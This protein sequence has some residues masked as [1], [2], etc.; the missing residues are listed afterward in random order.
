MAQR[1]VP[2][3]PKKKYY[4]FTRTERGWERR[5]VDPEP[6]TA[7][8]VPTYIERMQRDSNLARLR[9]LGVYV[10]RAEELTTFANSNTNM[11]SSL[12]YIERERHI[13]NYYPPWAVRGEDYPDNYHGFIWPTFVTIGIRGGSPGMKCRLL[14][15]LHSGSPESITRTTSFTGSSL[16]DVPATATIQIFTADWPK[17]GNVAMEKPWPDV[18]NTDLFDHMWIE[19]IP[20]T[21]FKYLAIENI[22]IVLNSVEIMNNSPGIVLTPGIRFVPLAK[23]IESARL[24]RVA[25]SRSSVI[26]A[27]AALELGKAWSPK[28]VGEAYGSHW[29]NP[30][31]NDWSTYPGWCNEFALWVLDHVGLPVP[32]Q[33]P[34]DIINYFRRE[35]KWISPG[36]VDKP[37]YSFLLRNIHPGFYTHIKSWWDNYFGPP[38]KS[39][40]ATFFIRWSNPG[41]SGFD[42]A[43]PI[44]YFEAINGNQYHGTVSVKTG[45]PESPL[46]SDFSVGTIPQRISFPMAPGFGDKVGIYWKYDFP[47]K[48]DVGKRYLNINDGFGITI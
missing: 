20:R 17:I 28:Y 42:P 1:F 15:G 22:R 13:A 10:P 32:Y 3:L 8:V 29:E 16:I 44:N 47:N 6:A 39:Y 7:E 36:N 21:E 12:Q 5:P 33:N 19:F 34:N 23:I 46:Y 40:H 26:L 18:L 41:V 14:F 9:S 35:N 45:G 25:G 2:I 37:P 31:N 48:S 30:N 4:Y 11:R 43:L 27:T 38:F 24:D